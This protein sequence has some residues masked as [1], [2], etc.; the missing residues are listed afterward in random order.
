MKMPPFLVL[1]LT[2]NSSRY[3]VLVAY[4]FNSPSTPSQQHTI[5]INKGLLQLNNNPKKLKIT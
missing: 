1:S 5:T 4:V 3:S 2:L